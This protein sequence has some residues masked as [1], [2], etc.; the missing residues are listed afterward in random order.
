MNIYS[1]ESDL[2]VGGEWWIGRRRG[3]RDSSLTPTPRAPV[4]SVHGVSLRGEDEDVGLEKQ[5]DS[6]FPIIKDEREDLDNEKKL[7]SPIPLVKEPSSPS[8]PSRDTR[9]AAVPSQG[10]AGDGSGAETDRDGVVKARLSGNWV[11]HLKRLRIRGSGLSSVSCF[12]V[13]GEDTQLL[14][15][16]GGQ[17]G[18]CRSKSDSVGRSGSA[19]LFMNRKLGR[20]SNDVKVTSVRVSMYPCMVPTP[21]CMH[22]IP[23]YDSEM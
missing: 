6:P 1:Y 14:S 16:G 3:K 5:L 18:S 10:G 23:S 19:I 20:G 15:I 21:C 7:D 8:L 12:V 17:L 4:R 11:S 13:R 2:A 9:T 22:S